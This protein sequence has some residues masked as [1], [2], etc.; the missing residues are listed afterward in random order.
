MAARDADSSPASDPAWR[1]ALVQ[2][3]VAA[4]LID[5]ADCIA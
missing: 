4:A 5:G 3:G 2:T 1:Q